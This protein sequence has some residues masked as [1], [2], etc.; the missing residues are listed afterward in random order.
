MPRILNVGA[1]II[2]AS[3]P[4]ALAKW[5]S[6]CLGIPMSESEGD[7]CFYGEIGDPVREIK[8]QFGILPAKSPLAAGP[9]AVMIN[10]RVDDLASFVAALEQRGVKI[11]RHESSQYG[12]FAHVE[13]LEGNRVELWQAP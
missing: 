12:H 13:D 5:Y 3:D 9:R 10:Y 8:A 6:D 11:L 2:T 7:G 1:V 4:A